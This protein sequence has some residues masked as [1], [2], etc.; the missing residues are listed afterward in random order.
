MTIRRHR[1]MLGCLSLGLLNCV[2][3]VAS[4]EGPPPLPSPI[5]FFR[6]LLE[7]DEARRDELLKGHP[8]VHRQVIEA[9]LREYS[10]LP[11]PEKDRRL[12]ATELRYYLRPLLTA[13]VD[14][15]AVQ[16]AS[17]PEQY[18]ELLAERLA[19]WDGLPETTRKELLTYDQA[20][21]MLARFRLS[22]RTS[23]GTSGMEAPPLPPA[24]GNQRLEAELEGWRALPESRRDELCRRFEEFFD[25]SHPERERAL[26]ELSA[27]ERREMESTLQAFAQLPPGQRRLC[28]GSFRRFAQLTPAE[29]AAFLRSADRW[30]ELSAAERVQWRRLVTQLPPLPPGFESPP[31]LPPPLPPVS[32]VSRED[33]P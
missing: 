4:A 7:A 3:F 19:R 30:R 6:Q 27:E 16:L 24:P 26:A 31:P 2:S 29:R 13:P 17:V 23:G 33:Q 15:R 32:L 25:L 9:K 1:L 28:I 18:R 10:A 21:A 11:E 8:T 20:L 22:S 14:N 5:T 12:R